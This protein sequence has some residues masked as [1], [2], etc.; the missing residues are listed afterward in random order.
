ML[1]TEHFISTAV[2]TGEKNSL[3]ESLYSKAADVYYALAVRRHEM[4][5]LRA[6][7]FSRAR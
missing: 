5:T 6:P 3:L 4:S 7:P 1:R 2:A